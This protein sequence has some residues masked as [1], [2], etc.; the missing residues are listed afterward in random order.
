MSTAHEQWL[1]ERAKGIGGSDWTHVLGIEPYGCP[2][3]LHYS[4]TRVEP[5]YPKPEGGVLKRGHK[6]EHLV[7]EEF[8]ELHGRSVW[9][10]RSENAAREFDQTFGFAKK[11]GRTPRPEWWVGTP[12]GAVLKLPEEQ[13][14]GVFEAKTKGPFPYMK[15][16]REGLSQ[17][18]LAQ[19][20]HYLGL[21][22]WQWGVS[23]YLE[24]V[25]WQFLPVGFDRDAEMLRLMLAA[26]EQFWRKHV[27]ENTAPEALD[28]GSQ[29]CR[30][31]PWLPT[32][33]GVLEWHGEVDDGKDYQ[34]SDKPE[35]DR[36][37]R[38]RVDVF[39]VKKQAESM[40]EDINGQLVQ[41]T[42]AGSKVLTADGHKVRVSDGVWKGTDQKA[43]A[44][45]YPKLAARIKERF[46][47]ARKG[48]PSVTV[49]PKRKEQKNG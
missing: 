47:V 22:G 15:V 11:I 40:I 21:S 7:V 17:G 36:L 9:Y 6:M 42:G 28:P 34:P 8:E 33:Q 4:K 13:T 19:R 48:T 5:D 46:A 10:P 31:C 18:E 37:V 3:Q 23:G 35:V 14:N 43:F 29:Q 30:E 20:Q 25:S 49:Y 39:E 27:V 1:N 2:R 26:G 41:L 16:L 24:V 38:E 32:C 12:D 45:K 44:A